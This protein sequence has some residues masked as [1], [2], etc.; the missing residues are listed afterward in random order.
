[1][2]CFTYPPPPPHQEINIQEC[3]VR[4]AWAWNPTMTFGTR[5]IIE[6]N[7]HNGANGLLHAFI[8]RF[9]IFYGRFSPKCLGQFRFSVVLKRNLH[10]VTNGFSHVSYKP[11]HRFISIRHW[12]LLIESCSEIQVL[13]DIHHESTLWASL[14]EYKQ[15]KRSVQVI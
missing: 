5:C 14:Y 8:N 3:Q 11:F 15:M 12:R 1:M 9:T 2:V 6:P 10:E 13:R 7:S 4:R